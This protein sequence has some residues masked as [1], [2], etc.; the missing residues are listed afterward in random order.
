M[1]AA[2]YA[3]NSVHVAGQ[4]KAERKKA[5][6][7]LLDFKAGDL[8]KITVRGGG[9]TFTMEKRGQ[10]WLIVSPIETKTDR[11]QLDELIKAVAEGHIFEKVASMDDLG[12]FGLDK[13]EWEFEFYTSDGSLPQR[14]AVGNLSPTS[15]LIYVTASRHD[16]VEIGRA[17]V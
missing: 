7:K 1:A 17:H 10:E 5:E 14:L 13:P 2:F 12:R 9:E 8:V 16:G 4:K 15:R 6:K 3:Y 11:S